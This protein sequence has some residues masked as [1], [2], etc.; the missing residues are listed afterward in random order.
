MDFPIGDGGITFDEMFVALLVTSF[1][2]N[3]NGNISF[4]AP[5]FSFSNGVQEQNLLCLGEWHHHHM[6]VMLKMN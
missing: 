3:E 6:K 4:N 1:E 2:N 5:N